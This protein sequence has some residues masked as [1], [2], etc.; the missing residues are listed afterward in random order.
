VAVAVL[1]LV[2]LLVLGELVGALQ[3]RIPMAHQVAV[4]QVVEGVVFM[5][6]ILL[7]QADQALS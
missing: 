4:T 2:A 6:L 5:G 3:V 1:I 7:A